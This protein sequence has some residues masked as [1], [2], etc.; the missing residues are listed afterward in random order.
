LITKKRESIYDFIKIIDKE[1]INKT[2]ITYITADDQH[3][4]NIFDNDTFQI[5]HMDINNEFL[6]FLRIVIDNKK[7]FER[8]VTNYNK[9]FKSQ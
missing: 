8:I 5:L 2:P 7:L 3:N 4:S 9:L 6:E 1:Y